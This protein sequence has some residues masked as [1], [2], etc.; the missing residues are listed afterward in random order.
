M[1][2]TSLSL[3]AQ[4]VTPFNFD[5]VGASTDSPY[6][7]KHVDGLDLDEVT[8]RFYGS[9]IDGTEKY[10]DLALKPRIIVILLELNPRFHLGENH[11]YLRD[12]LYKS[13]LAA[14]NNLME[15]QFKQNGST[16][17]NIYGYITKFEAPPFG[18]TPTVKLTLRCNDPL[19]KATT[20]T[21]LGPGSLEESSSVVTVSNPLST[22]PCGFEMSVTI[23]SA[24]P[25]L[26]IQDA[27]TPKWQWRV[28]QIPSIVSPFGPL[29]FAVGDVLFI[30]SETGNKYVYYVRSGATTYLM[31]RVTV[32]SIWP[33]LFPGTNTLYF[34][35]NSSFTWNY[36][37]F[38]PTYWGV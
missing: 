28:V 23:T 12:Q 26:T 33:K 5:I 22:A 4:N 25:H 17:G 16:V 27:A 34:P 21:S 7:I 2:I 14:R 32:T 31:D 29:N 18:K 35:E 30:S 3:L 24:I 9:S 10:H 6:L 8:P 15:I 11:A 19:I 20:R 38:Y 1:N 13:I 37:R 36:L